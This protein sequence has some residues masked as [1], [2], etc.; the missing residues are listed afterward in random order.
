MLD[1]PRHKQSTHNPNSYF[2][3]PYKR[4]KDNKVDL[5]P[6]LTPCMSELRQ[7]YYNKE[8]ILNKQGKTIH[9]VEHKLT[10]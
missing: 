5:H 9:I 10:D 6:E 3:M 7:D 1:K 4:I 2:Q 8:T